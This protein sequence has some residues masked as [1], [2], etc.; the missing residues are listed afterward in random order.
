MNR[1]PLR[2]VTPPTRAEHEHALRVFLRQHPAQRGLP[3]V[4]AYGSLLWQPE[5]E[6]AARVTARVHGWHRALNVLAIAARGTTEQPGLWFGLERGGSVHGMLIRPRAD[7][8]SALLKLWERELPDD[9]YVPRWVRATPVK[10]KPC[11]AIAFVG[12]PASRLYVGGL[13]VDECAERVRD[14]VGYRGSN[15]D[16]VLN[17]ATHLSELGLCDRRLRNV[18]ARLASSLRSP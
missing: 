2:L 1:T 4:F 3:W 16:Y 6:E 15:A 11:W 12:N 17:T 10:G 5:F 13:T 7:A 18:R 8:M 14:A 9:A